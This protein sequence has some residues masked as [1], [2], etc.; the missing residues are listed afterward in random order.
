MSIL[1][2]NLLSS[3]EN[4]GIPKESIMFQQDNDPKHSSKSAQNWFKSQ[5][6]FPRPVLNAI[7]PAK[8]PDSE[9]TR[10][11]ALIGVEMDFMVL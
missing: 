4:F 1:E 11:V 6:D 2:D 9:R 3:M 8:R 7:C 5:V 10:I